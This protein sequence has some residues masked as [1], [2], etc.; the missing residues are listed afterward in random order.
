MKRKLGRPIRLESSSQSGSIDLSRQNP[1]SE[2]LKLALKKQ[3]LSYRELSE[4]LS[5]IDVSIS[6]T[7]LNR[8]INRG[9]FSADFLLLCLCELGV[10]SI[11]LK[12]LWA[13]LKYGRV[14]QA[15][16][17]PALLAEMALRIR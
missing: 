16:K 10:S 4:R 7:L 15:N 12:G 3:K 13:E 14:A 9:N 5:A 2:L 8:R 1:A 17:G 11:R 6:P